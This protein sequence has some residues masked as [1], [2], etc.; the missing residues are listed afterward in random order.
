MLFDLNTPVTYQKWVMAATMDPV[1]IQ[2]GTLLASMIF[3][4]DFV[5]NWIR[6][7]K[8]GMC[9][10]NKYLTVNNFNKPTCELLFAR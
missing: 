4:L 8:F 2:G 7:F 3:I 5:H 10:C 1:G 6:L 9:L